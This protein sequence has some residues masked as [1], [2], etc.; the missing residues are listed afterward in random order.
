MIRYDIMHEHDNQRDVWLP[1]LSAIYGCKMHRYV[2]IIEGLNHSLK[3]VSIDYKEIMLFQEG[4]GASDLRLIKDETY[5]RRNILIYYCVFMIPI[6]II[7][8]YRI[9]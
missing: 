8:V 2:S 5:Q 3:G 6:S 7:P 4:K 1:L 9:H